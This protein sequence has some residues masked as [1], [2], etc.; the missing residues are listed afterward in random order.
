MIDQYDSDSERANAA[1]YTAIGFHRCTEFDRKREFTDPAGETYGAK[2]DRYNPITKLYIDEKYAPLNHK[3]N[4]AT[5]KRGEAAAAARYDAGFSKAK[6]RT[7][8]QLKEGWNHAVAKHVGVQQ[9][10]SPAVF[11]PV[12]ED[13]IEPE[14]LDYYYE[15]KLRVCTRKSLPSYSAWAMFSKLGIPCEFRLH[16]E[17]GSSVSFEGYERTKQEEA[18]AKKAIAAAKR[19]ASRTMG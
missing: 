17:A 14:D 1:A 10:L 19:K 4:R 16:T 13:P 7:S 15:K 11:V 6:S 3:K 5:A 9:V 2:P 18:A 8:Y 12:F